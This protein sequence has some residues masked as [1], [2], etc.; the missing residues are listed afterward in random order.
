MKA[1]IAWGLFTW[2]LVQILTTIPFKEWYLPQWQLQRLELFVN[3]C[4]KKKI[5]EV[6]SMY[7]CPRDCDEPHKFITTPSVPSISESSKGS[8]N[9]ESDGNDS[10]D[11]EKVIP[12]NQIKLLP[13]LWISGMTETQGSAITAPKNEDEIT[14]KAF[15]C[16]FDRFVGI[17]EIIAAMTK[18]TNFLYSVNLLNQREY[19]SIKISRSFDF[20]KYFSRF[21]AENQSRNNKQNYS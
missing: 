17:D 10:E 1:K 2:K 15:N 16:F 12:E 11:E 8:S 21:F 3:E 4:S 13:Y 6:S 19:Q 7:H 20:N 18:N 5:H 9:Y 14:L